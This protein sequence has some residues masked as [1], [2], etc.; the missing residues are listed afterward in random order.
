MSNR[1]TDD[2]IAAVESG[3]RQSGVTDAPNAA[4]KV[5]YQIMKRLGGREV[6][7]PSPRSV[8]NAP[9]DQQIAEMWN[10]INTQQVCEKFKVSKNTVYRAAKKFPHFRKT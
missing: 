7:I 10:G 8:D 2:I 9:R 4:A 5:F 1:V 3:L 6:Y